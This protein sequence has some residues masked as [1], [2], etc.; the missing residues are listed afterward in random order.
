MSELINDL[1][2]ELFVAEYVVDFNAARAAVEAGY[3]EGRARQ[4]GYDLLQ[5]PEVQ[6]AIKKE[7]GKRTKRARA[8]ADRVIEEIENLALYDPAD[9]ADVRGP[10]DIKALPE[11]VRRAIAGW[12]YD[13]RGNF[14]LK[15]SPKTPS[16][17]QLGKHFKL[18]TDKLELS[19]NVSLAERIKAAR[20]RVK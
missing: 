14:F 17:D 15:I 10:E 18:F 6:Q 2:V 1:R 13:A 12:G 19:G 4:T 5:R 16:L 8:T 3:S 20:E 9:F 7:L 11:H